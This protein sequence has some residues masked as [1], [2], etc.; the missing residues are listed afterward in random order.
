MKG[1][2]FFGGIPLV[3]LL[4]SCALSQDADLSDNAINAFGDKDSLVSAIDNMGQK[5][6]HLKQNLDNHDQNLNC[7]KQR[8][9]IL[10]TRL[11]QKLDRLSDRLDSLV[12]MV[13][14]QPEGVDGTTVRVTSE[15]SVLYNDTHCRPIPRD[16]YTSFCNDSLPHL[17]HMP[18]ILGHTDVESILLEMHQFVPL[19]KVQCSP[20]LA[21]FLCRAYFPECD[22]G[23][24]SAI[25]PCRDLC[26]A[27]KS[28]CEPLMRKFGFE[29]PSSLSCNRFQ[30]P[31]SNLCRSDVNENVETPGVQ[32]ESPATTKVPMVTEQPEGVDGTTVRVTSE[33]SALYNNTHC[34]PIPR[35]K[36]TSFCND[37]LPHLVHMPGILGHTDVESIL[38][39]IHQFFPLVKI[40]CSPQLAS[41]LCR[42]YFPECDPGV[43]SAIG[44]CRDLCEAAKSGCEPLMRKFGFEWPSSLS[45]NRFQTPDSS[46]CRS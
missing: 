3:V 22:P 39:E 4:A 5:I 10:E 42:A 31:T 28:G 26:E 34:R 12:P 29:W 25:G 1:L 36:Y 21:S 14:K 6:D 11:D 17:V 46:V 33:E 9:D 41:F 2:L 7:L 45:C 32:Y 18:G 30:T 19:V 20:H 23:V 8:L 15:E 37:S 40:Q 27:A 35:D 44:P 13:T 43:L 16:K 24:L 38:L